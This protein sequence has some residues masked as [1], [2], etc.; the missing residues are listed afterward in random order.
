MSRLLPIAVVQAAP[1]LAVGA[2]PAF[3][4]FACE[5]EAL[6]ADFPSVCMVVYPEAHLCGVSGSPVERVEQLQAAAEP[7]NGPR[8][9]ALA[10]LAG[11]LGIWLVPG[12][13]CE[14]GPS[15][16][17][18]NT[19]LVYSPQGELVAWYRKIF[20]WRPYEP[21]KP[22]DRFVVFDLPDVGRVGLSICYDT[23]FPEVA[24]HL[25]WMGAEVIIN[26]AQTSTSDRAQEYVLARANAIINQVF[27]VSANAAAPL[28]MGR[29]LIV[30]P[31][32]RVRVEARSEAATM[33]TDVLDFDDVSRVRTYG[34]AG[35]NRMWDFFSPDDDVLD[36]P[37]YQGRIEPA[38]WAPE[39]H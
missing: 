33:L 1:R 38:R 29:S 4:Q 34:T 11:D 9:G 35:V 27:V 36:L 18:F 10:A 24:R 28:G 32:G 23:W 19:A 20:V 8:S 21:Y 17:L 7:L 5:V 25:A 26:P 14:R 6:T 31:E 22:G 2:A 30:D 39:Q 15:G 16:E 37:L 13:V 12:T 3:A